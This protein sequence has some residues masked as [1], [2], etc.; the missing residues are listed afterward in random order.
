MRLPTPTLNCVLVCLYCTAAVAGDMLVTRSV[1]GRPDATDLAQFAVQ[2]L[3]TARGSALRLEQFGV[4]GSRVG[5]LYQLMLDN[6]GLEPVSLTWF[7]PDASP[8]ALDW[9][10]PSP[11]LVSIGAPDGALMLS[12][13]S[14]ETLRLSTGLE[15]RATGVDAFELAKPLDVMVRADTTGDLHVSW[16]TLPRLN[17]WGSQLHFDVPPNALTTTHRGITELA[18]APSDK[19]PSITSLS[20]SG[21]S[22]AARTIYR[23][24]RISDQPMAVKVLA[25]SAVAGTASL[26]EMEVKDVTTG[27]WSTVHAT[28]LDGKDGRLR[29]LG[30]QAAAPPSAL[31]LTEEVRRNGTAAELVANF[32]SAVDLQR[33]GYDLAESDR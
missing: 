11:S 2:Q 28:V 16:K 18:P 17:L 24:L 15:L 5:A 4:R 1:A 3:E 26:L 13:G 23:N 8:D 12:D 30:A 7:D 22:L 10:L 6:P 31:T 32:Q 9:V 33:H 19:R 20:I 21:S 29:Y 14:P 27:R 25:A